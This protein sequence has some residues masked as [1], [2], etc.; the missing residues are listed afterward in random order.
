MKTLSAVLLSLAVVAA[1]CVTSRQATGTWGRAQRGYPEDVLGLRLVQDV[2]SGDL[3]LTLTNLASHPITNFFPQNVF[4]G[5]IWVLQEGTVPLKTYP[6]N[7]FA[8]CTKAFWGNPETA[9]PAKGCLTYRVSLDSLI[10]P[11][12]SRA[13]EGTRSVTAYA[14]MDGL[15]AVSNV[16][17]LRHQENIQWRTRRMQPTPR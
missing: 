11:F 1:G 17:P 2:E 8:L 7:Y 5:S 10:C 16:I 6:S 12:S 4:E 9:I 3:V 15:E 14:Y 13:P